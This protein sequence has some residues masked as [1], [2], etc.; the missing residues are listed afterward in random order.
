MLTAG[1][2]IVFGSLFLA[3]LAVAVRGFRGLRHTVAVR[4]EFGQSST[5]EAVV[6]LYPVG[7]LIFAAGYYALPAVVA[8]VLAAVPFVAGLVLARNQRVAL[9]SSGTDRVN[10]ALEATSSA[11]LGA[12]IGLICVVLAAMFVLMARSIA[13]HALGA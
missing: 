10:E 12:I 11:S 8:F 6:L 2:T 4:R 13:A 1:L 5:L 9:E 3:L 7:I